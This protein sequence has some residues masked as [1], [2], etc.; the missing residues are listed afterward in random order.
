[1]TVLRGHVHGNSFY[2]IS[3]LL[4]WLLYLHRGCCFLSIMTQDQSYWYMMGTNGIY[5]LSYP[6]LICFKSCYCCLSIQWPI[7]MRLYYVKIGLATTWSWITP[8]TAVLEREL[9]ANL[10]VF[11]IAYILACN[12]P[13]K[14]IKLLKDIIIL[15]LNKPKERIHI[16][17]SS[18]IFDSWV[19]NLAIESLTLDNK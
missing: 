4:M 2:H 13:A 6:T 3:T 7:F 10:Y 17:Q 16:C 5:M 14:I 9:Q 11:V 18:P 12:I 1:M 19:E 8:A 15:I